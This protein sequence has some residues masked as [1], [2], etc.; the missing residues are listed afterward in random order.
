MNDLYIGLFKVKNWIKLIVGFQNGKGMRG[1]KIRLNLY[2]IIVGLVYSMF[3]WGIGIDYS[4]KQLSIEQGLPGANVQCALQDGRG[5]MWFGIE[6]VGL[7]KYDGK[8]FTVFS[9]SPVDSTSISNNFP[10]SI[11]EDKEGYIWVGTDNG[12]NR[13][14]RTTGKFQR[15]FH[16][17]S[18]NSIPND[19]IWDLL[20]DDYDNIWIATQK[21]VSKYSKNTNRF[22]NLL[23]GEGEYTD[24]LPAIVYSFYQDSDGNIWIGSYSSGL[25]LIDAETNRNHSFA[26]KNSQADAKV[27]NIFKVSK[28][29]F[30]ITNEPGKT[31]NYAIQ[32]LTGL[33]EDTL[34]I[35]KLDGLF[36]FDKKTEKFSRYQIP[37]YPWLSYVGYSTLLK[38]TK[39]IIWA[40]TATNGLLVVDNKKSSRTLLDANTY[41]PDGLKGNNIR[42]LL[43]DRS[44]LIWICTKFQG[45]QTYDKR[46]EIFKEHPYNNMFGRNV[47]SIF[48]LSILEDSKGGLWIGTK[49]K[50]LIWFDTGSGNVQYLNSQKLSSNRIEALDEDNLGNIWIGTDKGVNRLNKK[51]QQVKKYKEI[52][53]RC[54]K[55]DMLGNIWVGSTS[56]GVYYI[57]ANSDRFERYSN[58][59]HKEFFSD[60][61]LGIRTITFTSDSL[62][63]FTSFQN[64][65]YKYN[66]NKDILTHYQNDPQD[67]STIS[68]NMV[69]TVYEDCEGGIWISTKSNSLNKYDLYTGKFTRMEEFYPLLPNTVYSILQ[70]DNGIMWMGSHDGLIK[71]DL[72]IGDF[73]LYD[74]SDGLNTTVF[75]VN[76]KC[77]T[78]DGLLIFGGSNGINFFDPKKVNRSEYFAQLVISSLKIY[79]R[80][81]AEDINGY[82]EFDIPYSDKFFSI[83]FALTEYND[84]AHISYKYKLENFDKEWIESGNRNYASYTSLPPGEYVFKLIAANSEHIWIE[85]PLVVKII[86]TSPL[87]R[88][89]VFIVTTIILLLLLAVLVN[90]LRLRF[91]R[92]NEIRLKQL[93]KIQ[94]EDLIEANVELEAHRLNLEKLVEERTIDLEEAMKRAENSDKLK[95]VFLANMSH[96]IRTPLNA[97]IGLTNILLSQD[98]DDEEGKYLKGLVESNGKALL[99][100]INDIIDI[101]KIEADQIK[102]FKET[103][104]I[105]ECINDVADI[106]QKQITL[107]KGQMNVDVVIDIP[108]RERKIITDKIRIEQI[109]KNLLNNAIKF[110]K[111]GSITVGYTIEKN[112][113]K[114]FIRFFVKDT[115]VGISKEDLN[116]VF[117]RFIKS[118]SKENILYG[119]TGLGLAISFN[120]TRLLGGK[121]WVE[122]EINVGSTF[123]F[124]IP[125]EQAEEY[126]LEKPII[127]AGNDEHD[128]TGKTVLI[129]EDEQANFLVIRGLLKFTNVHIIHAKNG[130]IAVNMVT[131][132]NEKVDLILM[133]IKMPQM[134]GMEAAAKIKEFDSTIPVI[135]QTAY[136]MDYEEK[137]IIKSGFDGY[138]A[139]PVVPRLL[140]EK[141]AVFL[142]S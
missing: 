134:D 103:F 101:S 54:I 52:F 93:V 128:W 118:E 7:C 56:T 66:L 19:V 142:D 139:K 68:G 43:E 22:D 1:I 37:E 104:S 55:S 63:W 26:N 67:K 36:L 32:A 48:A 124:E 16:S 70:D 61:S 120:L 132:A 121:M 72:S 98:Y 71:L 31:Q 123:F 9:N 127:E 21:G 14:D 6:S 27:E 135:A 4:L 3:T 77:K 41:H 111:K 113:E 30:P 115:G 46:Q 141:M 117:Q 78:R 102:I 60:A 81:V 8:K 116:T 59:K 126:V 34:L 107:Y 38:D 24:G 140:I 13:Y 108:S 73:V 106:Y 65:L 87:W 11:V 17:D 84:P 10:K 83:E 109:L 91:I 133:D 105:N 45:I 25:F 125:L 95:S 122:S 57:D 138:I 28:H 62:I 99:Q 131:Q 53:I 35:G 76:A 40:G 86:I 79:D 85:E 58:T 90:I 29:W 92:R 5:L 64:G 130:Q 136:A 75:E 12:L 82:G 69:R 89:P 42:F 51:T 137:R 129:A 49:N 112:E 23:I 39:G 15:Y 44:G 97:I 33:N 20:V 18:V 50:G 47:K 96:E 100:L 80:V 114:E 74:E 88:K 119:G 2:L 110:T 94:T